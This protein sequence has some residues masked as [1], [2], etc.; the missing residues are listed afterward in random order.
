MI[1]AWNTPAFILPTKDV[2]VYERSYWTTIRH[3]T[4]FYGIFTYYLFT[5][6]M[7]VGFKVSCFIW[8]MMCEGCI[9]KKNFQILFFIFCFS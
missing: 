8:R 7:I 3:V 2:S 1:N 6:F 4:I 9:V 5:V